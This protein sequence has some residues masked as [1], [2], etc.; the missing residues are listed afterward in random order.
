MRA[1]IEERKASGAVGRFDHSGREAALPHG[2][3][4]LVAGEPENAD[5]AAE[6]ARLGEPKIGGTVA[7]AREQR[8]RHAEEL[9]QAHVPFSARDV[10]EHRTCRIGRI[11]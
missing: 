1:R 2:C 9:A 7:R 3:G 11:G 10:E 6:E 4:L 5:G 8:R